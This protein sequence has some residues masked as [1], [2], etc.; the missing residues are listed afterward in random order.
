MARGHVCQVWYK[1]KII[2]CSCHHAPVL[3][4][5]NKCFYKA[6]LC[7]CIN[8]ITR[9]KERLWD[10]SCYRARVFLCSFLFAFCFLI[11]WSRTVISCLLSQRRCFRRSKE[12]VILSGFCS[13]PFYICLFPVY[14]SSRSLAYYNL[15]PHFCNRLRKSVLPPTLFP[16]LSHQLVA[17]VSNPQALKEA[18]FLS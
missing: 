7:F 8:S 6:I 12:Q 5:K 9:L 11:L 17:R 3:S 10:L 4:G 15:L 2:A 16:W 18:S 14:F 13:P 1:D